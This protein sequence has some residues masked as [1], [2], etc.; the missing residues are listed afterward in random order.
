MFDNDF[1]AWKAF[2]QRNTASNSITIALLDTGGT[3]HSHHLRKNVL[4]TRGEGAKGDPPL[5]WNMS[6]STCWEKCYRP[7]ANYNKSLTPFLSHFRSKR[8]GK[9][10]PRKKEINARFTDLARCPVCLFSVL[11]FV[12]CNCI[13]FWNRSHLAFSWCFKIP[14]IWTKYVKRLGL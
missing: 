2:D 10:K 3:L 4:R 8:R 12:P 6:L 13:I 7:C 11:Q 14:I 9:Q 5:T 1:E